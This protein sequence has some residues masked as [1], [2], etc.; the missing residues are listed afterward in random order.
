MQYINRAI[1][2][3]IYESG[4]SVSE[5]KIDKYVPCVNVWYHEAL[6]NDA[7]Q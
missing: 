1:Y 2:I 3:L 5:V 4:M 7:N 6:P